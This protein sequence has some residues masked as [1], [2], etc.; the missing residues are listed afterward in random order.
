[1]GK[2]REW[3][4]DLKKPLNLQRSRG[5]DDFVTEYVIECHRRI[6]LLFDFFGLHAKHGGWEHLIVLLCNYWD[7]PGFKLS[8]LRRGAPKRWT[9]TKN[10]ELFADV[11]ALVLKSHISAHG[12]CGYIFKHSAKYGGRYSNIKSKTLYRQFLRAKK[13]IES[14]G[15]FRLVHF[16]GGLAPTE[17]GPEFIKVAIK[18]HGL[19]SKSK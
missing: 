11:M 9:D 3:P 13:L 10:C 2:A 7:I 15:I 14:D 16:G 18:K 17:Y 4:A 8:G 5:D 19:R 6:R 12:A 1:M